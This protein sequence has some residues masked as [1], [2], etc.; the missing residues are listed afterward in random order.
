MGKHI[1]QD[2][3]LEY[4][5]CIRSWSDMSLVVGSSGPGTEKHI[6]G[7]SLGWSVGSRE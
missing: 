7:V 2:K 5:M 3:V 6:V 1:D 4:E